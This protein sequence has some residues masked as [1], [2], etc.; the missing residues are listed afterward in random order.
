MRRRNV[1]GA[2]SVRSEEY[3]NGSRDE[4]EGK[5]ET[6]QPLLRS[7]GTAI[8]AGGSNAGYI[9]WLQSLM[10]EVLRRC[11][12][13]L[14]SPFS[15]SG[16][17]NASVTPAPISEAVKAVLADLR[18]RVRSEPFDSKN[19]QHEAEL[20]EL[21]SL[22]FPDEP[23]TERI[24]KKW[25]QLGFQGTD[26]ATDFRGSGIFGLRNLLFFGRS[27]PLPFRRLAR[28]TF[29][30]SLDAGAA[31]EENYPFAITGINLTNL[32]FE[33]L[34]WGMR[35]SESAAKAQLCAMLVTGEDQRQ[36]RLVEGAFEEV[37]CAAFRL[38]DRRW[39]DM[40]AK[41]M[42]FP[43]VIAAAKVDLETLLV[44]C[45]N[46]PALRQENRREWGDVDLISL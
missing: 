14:W 21:W 13:F 16:G 12:A 36:P 32:L 8:I 38:F 42:D 30:P 43:R 22:A 34:G 44:S 46:L 19:S 6:Q 35:P 39:R 23:L 10:A 18:Q 31:M 2:P 28:G 17:E 3:A 9:A 26:P 33:I 1:P 40:G 41:Y 7:A 11:W 27:Y 24:T 4:D 45:S 5:E 37:Y 15:L 20:A 25:G 29:A